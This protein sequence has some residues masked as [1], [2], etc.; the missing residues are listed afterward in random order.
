ME[1]TSMHT[2][3]PAKS[4]E[5][6]PASRLN[7]ILEAQ[8][9]LELESESTDS[10]FGM[11]EWMAKY[12]ME[13][14]SIPICRVL[15]DRCGLQKAYIKSYTSRELIPFLDAACSIVDNISIA[16]MVLPI[17]TE[18]AQRLFGR[19]VP[20]ATITQASGD[21]EPGSSVEL[22]CAM[23]SSEQ[24]EDMADYASTLRST[25][26]R[27]LFDVPKVF[28]ETYAATFDDAA[29]IVAKAHPDVGVDNL[30]AM[31][32][33]RF[34]HE[35]FALNAIDL[36]QDVS[37][38]RAVSC[39]RM[40]AFEENIPAFA[41]EESGRLWRS[42]SI[43]MDRKKQGVGPMQVIVGVA[44]EAAA[45]E[46]T[47][48]RYRHLLT[49]EELTTVDGAT[50]ALLD[51]RKAVY[52][53]ALVYD[54]LLTRL[55]ETAFRDSRIGKPS[56]MYPFPL[57]RETARRMSL[58]ESTQK[59]SAYPEQAPTIKEQIA[60]QALQDWVDLFF[61]A[62][63]MGIKPDLPGVKLMKGHYDRLS[64]FGTNDASPMQTVSVAPSYEI[65]YLAPDPTELESGD[66]CAE[67]S[68]EG[69]DD[70]DF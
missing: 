58:I 28:A 27:S 46:P 48:G 2:L 61:I 5:E 51:A 43:F 8:P 53:T 14:S 21:N 25:S 52:Y 7:V 16:P 24:I 57:S 33:T 37:A 11:E 62:E 36:W 13:N 44:L 49:P 19:S 1:R 42:A 70:G 30:K 3:I 20:L 15:N 10:F 59:L 32:F 39:S 4:F 68:D 23:D 56:D 47:A 18:T 34:F 63:I 64:V 12:C 67:H 60:A 31:L 41:S 55:K 65:R 45:H 69:C 9:S 50:R 35:T 6:L 66:Y 54:F 26:I 17:D 29:S 22:Y 40:E 38:C